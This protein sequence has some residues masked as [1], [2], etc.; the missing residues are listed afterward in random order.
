MQQENKKQYFFREKKSISMYL[1]LVI[2]YS[3]FRETGNVILVHIV[4]HVPFKR[5]RMS[6]YTPYITITKNICIPIVFRFIICSH[7]RLPDVFNNHC[8]RHDYLIINLGPFEIFKHT[9]RCLFRAQ[10][11][12]TKDGIVYQKF[13][14]SS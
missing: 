6:L 13:I 3:F 14:F 5:L 2:N 8:Y 4:G 1:W 9:L 11:E 10:E 12:N 7:G